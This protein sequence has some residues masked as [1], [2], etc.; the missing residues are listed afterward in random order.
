ML[1]QRV[2]NKLELSD[3]ESGKIKNIIFDLGGVVINISYQRALDAFLQLG[4][5]EFDVIYSQIKQTHLFDLLETGQI[6]PQAFCN[7]IRKFKNNLTD[8]DIKHAWSSMIVDMPPEHIP[9]LKAVRKHYNTFLLSNTNDIHIEYFNRYLKETF[10]SNPLPEM[11]DRV[12]YSYEIHQRKPDAAAY[13]AVLMDSGLK[14]EETLFIDDLFA[15]IL[16]AQKLGIHAYHLENEC[17]SDLFD[18]S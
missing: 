13:E 8:E 15:N 3:I 16:A 10:G 4:F 6:P 18:L 14:P 12:Y 5:N 2:F 17:I 11:F 9:L 1:N 7:E